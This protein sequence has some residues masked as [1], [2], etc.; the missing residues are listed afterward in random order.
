MKEHRDI[1]R[2]YADAYQTKLT[3]KKVV[4][5]IENALT[6]CEK[7]LDIFNLVIIRQK[8]EMEVS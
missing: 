1:C 8:I 5:E 4:H 3:T 7:R 2:T 6:D